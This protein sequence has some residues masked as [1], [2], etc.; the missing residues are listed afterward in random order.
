MMQQSRYRLPDSSVS[1]SE[2]QEVLVAW[3][4]DCTHRDT[5]KLTQ[6][7]EQTWPNRG[8]PSAID[9]AHTIPYSFVHH[10][11]GIDTTI[12]PMHKRLAAALIG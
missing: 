6:A 12:H 4:T 10:L 5:T 3:W 7:I 11:V 8:T 9:M 2:L 1:V